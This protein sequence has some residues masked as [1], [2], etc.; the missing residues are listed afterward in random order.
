MDLCYRQRFLDFLGDLIYGRVDV[1]T[2]Q[3]LGE[4]F[5]LGVE[6]VFLCSGKDGYI[7][8]YDPDN[9]E[10]GCVENSRKLHQVFKILVR[11]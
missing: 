11:V 6:K 1:N 3:S 7:P 9:N 10:Y 5:S 8:K 2:V 4:E